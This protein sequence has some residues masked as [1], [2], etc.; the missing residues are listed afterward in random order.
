MVGN[1]VV[2]LR[3]SDA[4]PERAPRFDARV[5]SDD[6]LVSLDASTRR[7]AR[8]W[9]LWAAKEAA[10]KAAVREAPATVFSPAGFRVTFSAPFS[11]RLSKSQDQVRGSVE[12]PVGTLPVCVCERDGA[13]HALV[14]THPDRII[15]AMTRVELDDADPHA[16]GVEARRFA[17]GRLAEE[18]R[19]EPTSLE[20]RKRG[21]VP[22][23]WI[24]GRRSASISLSHHGNVVGF[25]CEIARGC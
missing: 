8:R 18:L 12:T 19:I 5:F 1:D 24:D 15:A 21:R 4:R 3:D 17:T 14:S 9:Q 22:E 23:L 20:I 7:A 10:Y 11:A 16:P 2:D 25:A 6:E 13:V